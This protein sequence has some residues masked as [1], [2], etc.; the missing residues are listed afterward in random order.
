MDFKYF[1]HTFCTSKGYLVI[2][3]IGLIRN[4]LNGSPLIRES[5]WQRLVTSQKAGLVSVSFCRVIAAFN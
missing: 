4:E 2:R 3:C 1:L 5:L